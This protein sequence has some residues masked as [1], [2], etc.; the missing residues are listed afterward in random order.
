[1]ARCSHKAVKSALNW[2]W[3]TTWISWFYGI[4][5][6]HEMDPRISASV[7]I[8][9][10]K[11]L[12]RGESRTVILSS[13]TVCTYTW[14][15]VRRI[16]SRW[17]W[18]TV[19]NPLEEKQL[20]RGTPPPRRNRKLYSV[21]VN[22]HTTNIQLRS[23]H[24]LD[25]DIVNESK[26]TEKRCCWWASSLVKYHHTRHVISRPITRDF[27]IVNFFAITGKNIQAAI[28]LRFCASCLFVI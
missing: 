15:C 28:H 22:N 17:W 12:W 7:P 27:F 13:Q 3:I 8:G 6:L 4:W 18:K 10:L 21:A 24:V 5:L 1:M 20:W 11:T 25:Y 19:W 26:G 16:K 14:W 23:V 2:I 9:Q